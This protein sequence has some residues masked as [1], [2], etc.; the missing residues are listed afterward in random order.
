VN[1]A[2][3][4]MPRGFLI[5]RIFGT[6]IFCSPTFFLLLGFYFY[7][8]GVQAGALFSL[9]VVVSILVHEFGHVFAVRWLLHAPSVVILWGLGGLTVHQKAG[10][11]G[12]SVAISLMGPAFG[13][14]LCALCLLVAILLPADTPT[15]VTSFVSLMV[16]INAVWTAV[17]LL[18]ILPLDGGQALRA[19]LGGMV[20][21]S[22]AAR[23]TRIV[24]I[25]AAAA[26]M[27]ACYLY[28][29]PFLTLLAGLLLF[30]NLANP[31]RL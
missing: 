21:P 7:Q 17:N 31:H 18:P 29:E 22:P 3:D 24:S 25:A 13:F 30:Q 15:L 11:P 28:G 6:D 19:G 1:N 26:A 20:G 12:H 10:R 8:A 27:G 2:T 9:A 14:G 5:G 23:A 16:W 4:K